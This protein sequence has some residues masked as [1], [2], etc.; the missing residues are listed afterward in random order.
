VAT[1]GKQEAIPD[2]QAM[3]VEDRIKWYYIH[4][5]GSIQDYA[6]WERMSVDEVLV[7]IGQSEMSLVET[8]GDLIDQA[9]AG[10]GVPL[11]HS[12]QHYVQ[13]NTD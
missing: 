4:G 7:I 12:K 2:L 11:E 13:Y 8:Q 5:K 6:R 9:E 3:S 1:E 10:P